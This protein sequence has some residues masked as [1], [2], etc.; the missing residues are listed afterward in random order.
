MKFLNV[1]A[2][3]AATACARGTLKVQKLLA[4]SVLLFST[5]F[6]AALSK[7]YA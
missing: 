4:K 1:K 5:Q 6:S 3:L 7:L 2:A